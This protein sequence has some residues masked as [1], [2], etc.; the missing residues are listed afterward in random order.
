MEVTCIYNS[1]KRRIVRKV[2]EHHRVTTRCRSWIIYKLSSVDNTDCS[3]ICT[4]YKQYRL[5]WYGEIK[6]S[7][8]AHTKKLLNGFRV[9][10]S[11]DLRQFAYKGHDASGAVLSSLYAPH[12]VY[13]QLVASTQGTLIKNGDTRTLPPRVSLQAHLSITV[14]ERHEHGVV[15][16]EKGS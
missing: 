15:H 10:L 14:D 11:A 2:R 9:T 4:I 8:C 12:L 6:L 7:L 3:I 16:D 13:L 5:G 1:L